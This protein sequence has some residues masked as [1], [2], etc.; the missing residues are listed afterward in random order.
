MGHREPGGL[1]WGAITWGQTGSGHIIEH[2][3]QGGGQRLALSREAWSS[4][5]PGLVHL[6]S[7]VPC[8][9]FSGEQA[10]PA[11]CLMPPAQP[12][13][14]LGSAGWLPGVEDSLEGPPILA[15]MVRHG[16]GQPISGFKL[17]MEP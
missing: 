12:Q 17:A 15:S 5:L 9:D 6:P 7:G 2:T 10:A 1:P 3:A 11:P 14:A 8:A 13:C 4:G 16:E